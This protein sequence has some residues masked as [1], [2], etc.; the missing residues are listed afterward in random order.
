M[1]VNL[2]VYSLIT[3]DFDVGGVVDV[4]NF[5]NLAD[6]ANYVDD[7]LKSVE[8]DVDFDPEEER[9]EYE[10]FSKKVC[11]PMFLDDLCNTDFT[12]KHWSINLP[13]NHRQLTLA[14]N[15]L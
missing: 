14:M 1:N 11:N 12:K 7:I 8:F 9:E 13:G 10:K 4:S 2:K 15:E 3:F 6:A 5:T